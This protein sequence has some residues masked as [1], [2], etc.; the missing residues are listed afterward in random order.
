MTF[1][2]VLSQKKLHGGKEK[3]AS[4]KNQFALYTDDDVFSGLKEKVQRKMDDE[5]E[6]S[7]RKQ[8][9]EEKK[10]EKERLKKEKKKEQSQ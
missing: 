4:T 6:K 1:L 5:R 9:C 2:S 10:A 3:L 7:E 8:L